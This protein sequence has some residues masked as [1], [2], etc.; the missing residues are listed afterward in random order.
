[1]HGFEPFDPALLE[2]PKVKLAISARASEGQGKVIISDV[3]YD[4]FCVL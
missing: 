4:K 1:M 3:G 2:N